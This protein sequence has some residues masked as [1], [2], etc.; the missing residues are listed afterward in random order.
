[1]KNNKVKLI[2]TDDLFCE[3]IADYLQEKDPSK[4]FKITF[5]YFIK[6]GLRYPTLYS[7]YQKSNKMELIK[8]M[9]KTINEYY[10]HDVHRVSKWSDDSILDKAVSQL[11]FRDPLKRM[12]LTYSSLMLSD[13]ILRDYIRKNK[14]LLKKL[15]EIID[16]YYQIE[17]DVA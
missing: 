2:W 12:G 11:R 4:R 10:G 14:H 1:M 6:S 16:E 8:K 7:Y 9:V 13:Q 15:R 3:K 17:V 5:H